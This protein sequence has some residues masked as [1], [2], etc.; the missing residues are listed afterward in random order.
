MDDPPER[1][2]SASFDIDMA[3]LIANAAPTAQLSDARRCRA[4]AAAHATPRAASTHH[5]IVPPLADGDAPTTG[6][7]GAAELTREERQLLINLLTVEIEASKY[8]LSPRLEQLK[9]IGAKLSGKTIAPEP[10]ARPRS[11]SRRTE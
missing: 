4:R 2:P 7:G 5:P 8:P 9:R 1:R 10:P 3:A 11:R 6:D